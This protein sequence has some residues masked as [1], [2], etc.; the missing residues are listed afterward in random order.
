[1]VMKFQ[2]KYDTV[3]SANIDRANAVLSEIL[4]LKL[5][6][7]HAAALPLLKLE[8]K[9]KFTLF[10]H[11]N[12]IIAPVAQEAL[13]QYLAAVENIL[14]GPH[15]S[16]EK[17]LCQ[18]A[19]RMHLILFG[20]GSR[21]QALD[22]A[23]LR[24]LQKHSPVTKFERDELSAKKVLNKLL[25][26]KFPRRHAAALPL[27]NLEYKV[28][29][30]MYLDCNTIMAPVAQEAFLQFIAT[31]EHILGTMH[32]TT[33]KYLH[34]LIRMFFK[35]NV[36]PIFS[37]QQEKELCQKALRMHLLLYGR[38]KRNE[39]LEIATARALR[40]LSPVLSTKVCSFCEESPLRADIELGGSTCSKVKYCCFC[41]Q[42]AHWEVH[43]ST[44]PQCGETD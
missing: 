26:L 35:D 18:K 4:K 7:R 22:T 20:R 24:A 23:T 12:T 6:R 34:E 39:I 11:C 1:M 19:L 16:V 9:I 30:A 41:C 38:D 15:R 8:W 5:P 28:K 2:A 40:R 42:V 25:R 36:P 21:D 43:R 33:A 17:H 10:L 44:C 31:L 14:Q 29:F 32:R 27:L 3:S 37:P 13:L